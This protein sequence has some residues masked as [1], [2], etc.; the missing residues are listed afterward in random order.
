MK[1]DIHEY[2]ERLPVEI[3]RLKPEEGERYKRIISPEAYQAHIERR[4]V[5]QG[6]NEGGS[7]GIEIDL[8]DL[9]HFVK[10]ELPELWE[11]TKVKEREIS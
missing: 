6:L 7:N 11:T 1:T 4:W 3:Y 8:V 2:W 9:L 10:K 5:I